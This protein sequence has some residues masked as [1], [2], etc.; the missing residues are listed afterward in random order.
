MT[1]GN[2]SG[3]NEDITISSSVLPDGASTSSNQTN[4][5]QTTQITDGTNSV[6]IIEKKALR[7]DSINLDSK[8]NSIINV[9]EKINL[10]LTLITDTNIKDMVNDNSD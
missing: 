6:E 5:T 7:I 3:G 9:L 2:A 4:N 1:R 8:L 10:H